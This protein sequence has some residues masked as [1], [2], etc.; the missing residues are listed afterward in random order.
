MSDEQIG[1]IKARV[2]TGP[3]LHHRTIARA[4]ATTTSNLNKWRENEQCQNQDNRCCSL[5][6]S[7]DGIHGLLILASSVGRGSR[8]AARRILGD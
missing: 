4:L 1:H 5:E 6:W 7:A 8:G 3:L 2:P